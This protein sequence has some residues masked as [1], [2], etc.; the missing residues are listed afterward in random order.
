MFTTP[1]TET[2]HKRF[3]GKD[4]KVL[5]GVIFGRFRVS[6]Q[7]LCKNSAKFSKAWGEATQNS[8]DL[9]VSTSVDLYYCLASIGACLRSLHESLNEASY[10]PD[11]LA[12]WEVLNFCQQHEIVGESLQDWF[13]TILSRQI[14]AKK[15]TPAPF[16]ENDMR[17]ML[18]PCFVFYQ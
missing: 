15:A 8:V 1:P 2:K 12:V 10:R 6:R 17:A 16:D 11:S 5:D 18:T 14:S 4:G 3:I 7:I 9:A 13:R